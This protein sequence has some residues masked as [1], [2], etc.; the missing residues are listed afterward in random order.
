M[1]DDLKQVLTAYEGWL[2][3]Q[4]LAKNTQDAYRFHVRKFW[5]YLAAISVKEDD[6]LHDPFARDY[7]VRDFK[8][9]LKTERKTPSRFLCTGRAFTRA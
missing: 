8:W 3:R 4:P 7:A 6:P 2:L 5:E 9:Y 1:A